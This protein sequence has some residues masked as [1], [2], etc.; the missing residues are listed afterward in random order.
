MD[1]FINGQTLRLAIVGVIVLAMLIPLS[2]VGGITSERQ[3]YYETAFHDIANAWGHAQ[4]LTGPFIAIPEVHRYRT[5]DPDGQATWREHRHVRVHLP[6]ELQ[7]QAEISHQF[8]H[9]SIYSVP[10]YAAAVAVSGAFE[11]PQIRDDQIQVLWD[12]AELL[13][14]LT[15]TQAITAM[16][17]LTFAGAQLSFAASTGQPWLGSG[18][19]VDLPDLEAGEKLPFAFELD[20]NGTRSFGFTPL[21]AENEINLASTW[22]H[23][24][25]SGR[26]LPKEYSVDDDGFTS[27]WSVHALARDLPAN[28]LI[29]AYEADLSASL[30]GVSL[31]QPITSYTV[32]DRGI[33]YGILFIGLTFLTFVCFEMMTVIRFHYIQYGVVGAGLV[34]FYLALLSLSEH[35]PFVWAYIAATA[36][37]S[38][39]VSWYVWVMTHRRRLAVWVFEILVALYVCLYVLLKLEAYSLLVGTGVLFVGL[40]ALMWATKHLTGEA[41]ADAEAEATQ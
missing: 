3:S 17:D 11:L 30:A 8:R 34:L 12:E 20:A 38:L 37:L 2:F 13:L 16:S 31:F 9:R 39:L 15:H 32:I 4:H 7:M 24:S 18:V 23:P 41:G 36:L 40:F 6:D 29:G 22:P 26:Y 27:S 1:R 5:E 10:V 25:F 33:K 28:W 14:G 19:H 21:G 35:V